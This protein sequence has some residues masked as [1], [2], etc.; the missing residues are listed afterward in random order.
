MPQSLVVVE[1]V[2]VLLNGMPEHDTQQHPRPHVESIQTHI[3][4]ASGLPH[5]PE[6]GPVH[7]LVACPNDAVRDPVQILALVDP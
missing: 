3:D 1:L 6:V 4:L 7:L 2:L 5:V